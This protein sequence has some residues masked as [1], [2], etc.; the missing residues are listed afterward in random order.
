MAVTGHTDNGFF[1][2]MG[3]R[4]ETVAGLGALVG[5]DSSAEDGWHTWKEDG[6]AAGTGAVL[7]VGTFFIPG[8]GEVGADGLKAG[9]IGARVGRIAA[10]GADLAVQGGGWLVK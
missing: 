3:E 2:Y 10:T 7:S 4:A 6:V 8:A 5:Y 1:R 9:S